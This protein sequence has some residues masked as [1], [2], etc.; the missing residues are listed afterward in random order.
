MWPPT[1]EKYAREDQNC[2]HT[3]LLI[4]FLFLQILFM[5]NLIFHIFKNLLQTIIIY[6]TNYKLL[7]LMAER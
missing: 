7:I 1:L 5:I 4:I 3:I 2:T 6:K